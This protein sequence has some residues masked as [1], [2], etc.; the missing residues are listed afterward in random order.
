MGETGLTI[1]Q[2][3]SKA[4]FWRG[5][6]QVINQVLRFIIQI[7]LV[8]LLKP[9]DFGLLA[10]VAV[11]FNFLA[12][13]GSIGLN[14]AI[15]QKKELSE[16]EISSVFWISVLLGLI[17][18]FL[19]FFTAPLVAKFYAQKELLEIT[20]VLGIAFCLTSFG[21]VPYALHC[22]FLRFKILTFN[23][24][25]ATFLSG[26]LAI[27]SALK[28]GGVW[29]LI[30]QILSYNFFYSLLNFITAHFQP[31]RV[32][33]FSKVKQMIYFGGNVF[34]LQTL[35]YFSQNVDK[36]L[37]GKYLGSIPL[38]FY[39][40][41]YR[42]M[43]FPLRRIPWAIGSVMYPALSLVQDNHQ[44]VRNGY[45]RAIRMIA[46]IV[47][48]AMLGLAVI[49]PE[50]IKIVLG[51]KWLPS[52]YVMRI[53][54]L[55]GAF[56]AVST[57]VEWIYYSQGRANLL[58]RVI[59]IFVLI[60]ITSFILGLKWGINGVATMY[61]L[62]MLLIAYPNFKIPFN[63]INLKLTDF[64]KVL[65]SPVCASILMA[66]SVWIFKHITLRFYSEV[67]ILIMIAEIIWGISIY[68]LLTLLINKPAM[69]E[70]EIF[71]QN[72]KD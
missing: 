55:I 26:L 33:N 43:L 38:G 32:L 1:T 47:T 67:S 44:A 24:L 15:I 8:R 7:V 29:S 12:L 23:D 61:G 64:L 62:S 48:P 16:E 2:K 60:Y 53:F 30:V 14:T 27:L 37:I 69:K 5:I 40:L 58:F 56:Q 13:S 39:D 65:L 66:G 41:A 46:S 10:M 17:L 4:L 72:I 49:A 71:Y 25:G 34:G 9:E 59:I 18:S 63:L 52:L 50:F 45:L 51:E 28:G 6:S 57:T 54:C 36:L 3:T 42:I 35:G 21:V 31:R 11:F 22:K 70:L 68:F 19:M 20:P